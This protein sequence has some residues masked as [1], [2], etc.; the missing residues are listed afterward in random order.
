LQF[1]QAS[2]ESQNCL[3]S[4]QNQIFYELSNFDRPKKMILELMI[5]EKQRNSAGKDHPG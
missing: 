1:S 3:R 2:H 4:E 5:E